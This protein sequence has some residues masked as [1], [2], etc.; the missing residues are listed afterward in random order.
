MELGAYLGRRTAYNGE[1]AGTIEI[2]GVNMWCAQS[3]LQ[4]RAGIEMKRY[5]DGAGFYMVVQLYVFEGDV[6]RELRGVVLQH[7]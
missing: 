7:F 3:V 6:G 2:A 1:S 4:R 5:V